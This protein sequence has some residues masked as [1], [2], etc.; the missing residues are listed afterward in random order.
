MKQIFHVLMFGLSLILFGG[1]HSTAQTTADNEMAWVTDQDDE[2]FYLAYSIPESDQFAVA[3][4]C[5]VKTKN[6][7]VVLYE[8][9]GGAAKEGDKFEVTLQIGNVKTTTQAQT[10][11]DSDEEMLRSVA[12][13]KADDP[14]F[15]AIE[16]GQK[17]DII[18]SNKTVSYPLTE[19][20]DRLAEFRDG[21]SRIQ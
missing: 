17:L 15:T 5:E 16:D 3:F 11:Y 1:A 8:T 10:S 4:A 7:Y 20:A 13:L 14:I 6:T 9:Q 18:R 2:F 12:P 21:C 19:A